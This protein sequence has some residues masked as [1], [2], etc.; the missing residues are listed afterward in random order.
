MTNYKEALFIVEGDRGE[1]SLIKRFNNILN[2]NWNYKMYSFK[3]SIYELKEIFKEMK[4]DSDLEFLG[5]LREKN[6]KISQY[7]KDVLSKEYTSIFLVFDFDPHYHLFDVTFL[8]ELQCFFNDS[9]EDGKL[10]IN[11]PM[12]ES[13]KH[14][15]KMP[16]ISFLKSTYPADKLTKYKEVVGKESDYIQLASYTY[17]DLLQITA[18][19]LYKTYKMLVLEQDLYSVDAF[20]NLSTKHL[21]KIIDIQIEKIQQYNEVFILNTSMFYIIDI[22]P[23]SYFKKAKEYSI[24]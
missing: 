24:L 1:K 23:L 20:R 15:K 7:E 11:Y 22:A 4:K 12:L 14:L 21:K 5:L 6:P 2:K 9:R 17:I 10:Y 8:K 19:H 18:H 16:D 13:Y 3:L